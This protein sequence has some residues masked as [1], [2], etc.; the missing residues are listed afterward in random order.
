MLRR[1]SSS[2]PRTT[3]RAWASTARRR[4]ACSSTTRRCA[5]RGSW[6]GPACRTGRVS[7][8]VARG[9]DVAPTLLDYA[10]L[11]VPAGVEGRSLRPAANGRGDG[12]R[13]RVRRVALLP[14]QPRLGRAARLAERALQADRGAAAGALRRRRRPRRGARRLG[15]HAARGGDAAG[16]A[17]AGARDAAARRGTASPMPR[18]ASGCARSATSGGARRAGR[19]RAIRRTGSRSSSGWSAA[20]PRRAR[21]PGARRPGAHGL[22][23]REPDAPLARRHRAIAYQF[24]GRYDEADRRHPRARRQ[25]RRSRSRT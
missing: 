14:A 12:R 7:A 2:S 5:C 4:T 13:P 23:G 22:P 25:R 6:P 8:V 18:H 21:E 17:A 11:A 16:R 15:A 20:W 19:R 9:I 24:A 10:G 3:A 1:R